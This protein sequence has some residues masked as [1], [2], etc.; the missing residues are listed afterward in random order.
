MHF[1]DKKKNDQVNKNK[2]SGR[3]KKLQRCSLKILVKDELHVSTTQTRFANPLLNHP[4]IQVD[5][6]LPTMNLFTTIIFDNFF[7][8]S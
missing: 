3:P 1:I 6:H 8:K 4:K 7:C 2:P 5:Y